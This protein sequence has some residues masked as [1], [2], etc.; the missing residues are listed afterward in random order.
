MIRRKYL[1]LGTVATAVWAAALVLSAT[2]ATAKENKRA[3]C[4]AALSAYKDALGR[5]KAGH[6]REARE[7]FQSCAE[8]TACAGIAPKCQAAIEKLVEQMPSVVPVVTDASGAPM[9]DVQVRADGQL[10]TSHLDGRGIPVEA[11]AHEF[12]F[13]TDKGVFATQQVLIVEGE[14]NRRITIAIPPEPSSTKP[15]RTPSAPTAPAP[16]EEKATDN[17]APT[18]APSPAPREVPSS[19]G[20]WALPT[21]PLPYVVAGVGIAGIAGGILL[22]VW[23]RK[24]NDSLSSCTPNCPQASVDHIRNLYTLADVSLGVG[25]AGLGVATVM[26]AV[27]HRSEDAAKHAAAYGVTV[28]PTR[29]GALASVSGAF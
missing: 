7:A 9:L 12:T 21:S 28:Q 17:A 1:T 14:R 13:A 19:P 25:L 29:S 15:T 4:T 27:S 5:Q 26:F 10:L 16:P 6:L 2:P 23:G 18:E 22:T 8:A 20:P 24:D 3:V 11:G